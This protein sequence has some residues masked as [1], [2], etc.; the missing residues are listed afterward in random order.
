MI[1]M[2]DVIFPVIV[3]VGQENV[4]KSTL[5][6]RL[7]CTRDALVSSYP[8]LTRDRKYGY[9]KY[10][11]F[12]FI[13]IDTGGFNIFS[14]TLIQDCI[15]DQTN[16][17]I[18]ESCIILFV[19]DGKKQGSSEDWNII[20]YL[21]KLKKGIFVVINKID[22]A[23][24]YNNYKIWDYYLYGIKNVVIIS[25]V[26]GYGIST[27]LDKIYLQSLKNSFDGVKKC[28]FNTY[29]GFDD[30]Q[31]NSEKNLLL[32]QNN[33]PIIVVIIGRPN[34]GKSTFVNYLLKEERMIVSDIPGTTRDSVYIP[35]T[36]NNDKYMFVDTAGIRKKK[37]VSSVAEQISK[38]K[39]L[40]IL[41]YAHVTLFIL[42]IQ[43]GIVNQDLSLL[44]FITKS[45]KSLIIAVN[46]YDIFSSKTGFDKTLMKEE[47][48]K[49]IS[50]LNFV[51]IHYISALYG[52]GIKNLFQSI[53]KIHDFSKQKINTAQLTRV[54]HEA[55]IKYPPPFIRG[56][57]FAP[58]LK[59]VHV[60]SYNPVVFIIHGTRVS[61]LSN[62][63]RKYLRNY[64][65]R[66][67]NIEGVI[68]QMHFKNTVNPFSD[69]RNKHV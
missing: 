43:E 12:K 68:F 50:F 62:A 17:A 61:S 28:F 22:N 32:N 5:F 31:K 63:Y 47:L 42:D 36:Y 46:K 14:D 23:I 54:M 69:K 15:N 29:I 39:T 6:N 40:Q 37:H 3:L 45:S 56:T 55:I 18:Q 44:N 66:A 67:L 13:L 19:V 21:R 20:T 4:G 24:S 65:Y 7:T 59:F 53:K 2:N 33:E 58:K 25:A 41:K 38:L 64:F 49:K 9:I 52:S 8:G 35:I 16:I 60:G 26:H 57:K 10:K 34:S 51:K 27:L 48:N 30:Y 1:V 11:N